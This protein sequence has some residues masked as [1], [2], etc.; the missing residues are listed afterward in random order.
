VEKMAKNRNNIFD[1]NKH[2][3]YDYL[4]VKENK[5][6]HITEEYQKFLANL[7]YINVDK[8]FKTIQVTS[9]LTSEGKTTFLANVAYLL[10]QKKYK[11][12]VVDLDLR[13]PKIHYM[14]NVENKNGITDILSGRKSLEEG[15]KKDKNYGFD[16]LNSGEKTLAIT[17][18]IESN[19]M[20]ELFSKLREMYD[21]ILIDSPPIINV[22]DPLYISKY[23]DAMV[24]IIG[25]DKTKRK[26]VKDAVRSLKNNN[27][28][29]I[30]AVITQI[31]MNKK[32][33][34]YSYG[35]GY[36]YGYSYEYS[37]D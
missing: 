36:G 31:D 10:A 12:I 13:K 3:P 4:W 20:Q 23:S 21:Y 37:D 11:T 6:S 9:A 1:K 19:K 34:G 35:Y 8:K 7:E 29:I 22:S 16:I 15:I 30:G 25:S 33:Y 26:L 27:V 18:L 17:N 14:Y 5:I 32:G 28:N 2:I 24:F